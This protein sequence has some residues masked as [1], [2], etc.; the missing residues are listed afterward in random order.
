MT[1]EE[2][3]DSYIGAEK[4][5]NFVVHDLAAWEEIDPDIHDVDERVV[6]N[7]GKFEIT[8]HDK[9]HLYDANNTKDYTVFHIPKHTPH[10]LK[11]LEKTKYYVF[12]EK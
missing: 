8:I 5:V 9:K 2:C 7:N 1:L 6:A 11:T 12:K 3:I 4:D 10:S